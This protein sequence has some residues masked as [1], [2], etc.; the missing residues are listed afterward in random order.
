M[1]LIIATLIQQ[2]QQQYLLF[3]N[4][5]YIQGFGQYGGLVPNK[6]LLDE[7]QNYFY[8]ST[9]DGYLYSFKIETDSSTKEISL[10][11][12]DSLQVDSKNNNDLKFI[13][14]D[15]IMYTSDNGFYI[16]NI[17]DPSNIQIQDEN[18][19]SYKVYS[20]Y[21]FQ[22]QETLY[23]GS[24]YGLEIY[25]YQNIN[26]FVLIERIAIAGLGNK[27]VQIQTFTGSGI[28]LFDKSSYTIFFIQQ[29]WGIE[30]YE[31]YDGSSAGLNLISSNT[32]VYGRFDYGMLTSD[33][34]NPWKI[35]VSQ[36]QD[37]IFVTRGEDG[38][39]VFDTSDNENLQII[40]TYD[41]VDST[42][43]GQCDGL[44]ILLNSDGQETQYIAIA[45]SEDGVW[46]YDI[47]VITSPTLKVAYPIT[48]D[49]DQIQQLNNNPFILVTASGNSG[50]YVL[51]LS[52]SYDSFTTI[53]NYNDNLYYGTTESI[54]IKSDDS[55]ILT[56]VRGMGII[57]Y[58][59][60][61][62]YKISQ[63]TKV[64][65][66]GGEFAKWS[67][68]NENYFYVADGTQGLLIYYFDSINNTA[69]KISSLY[70]GGWA[71]KLSYNKEETHIFLSQIVQNQLLVINIKDLS[72][73]YLIE[74]LDGY[75]SAYDSQISQNVQTTDFE[76][77]NIDSTDS[78]LVFNDLRS[79]YIIDE[80]NFVN[81]EIFF[82]NNINFQ[83]S[84]IST[85]YEQEVLEILKQKIYYNPI[86]IIIE[87]S[88]KFDP[89]DENNSYIYTQAK[90]LSISIECLNTTKT[91]Q[92]IKK[93]YSSV[94][95]SYSSD[96]KLITLNGFTESINSALTDDLRYY[97]ENEEG[98]EILLKININD[99]INYE[100][101]E[102][103]KISD[104]KFLKST[105]YV[106]LNETISLQQQFNLK[107]KNGNVDVDEDVQFFMSS[108][109]FVDDDELTYLAYIKLSSETE[110]K[111]LG[112][113]S[114]YW[115]SF[116]QQSLQFKGSPD[117]YDYHTKLNL[118]I[119][120]TDG[121]TY[122]EDRFDINV[123]SLSL[124]I[125]LSYIGVI[126]GT[127]LF[128]TFLYLFRGRLFNI[129]C[130]RAYHLQDHYEIEAGQQFVKIVPI[131]RLLKN[132]G[133][134]IFSIFLK[135]IHKKKIHFDSLFTNF[136]QLKESEFVGI[137]NEINVKYNETLYKV[138]EMDQ[139]SDHLRRYLCYKMYQKKLK[140]HPKIEMLFT[141]IKEKAQKKQKLWYKV[142][143]DI[144]YQLIQFNRIPLPKVNFKVL[145]LRSMMSNLAPLQYDVDFQYEDF[146]VNYAEYVQNEYKEGFLMQKEFVLISKNIE[147]EALGFASDPI[148][149]YSN[150]ESLI[151]DQEELLEVQSL[152][153]RK[154]IPCKSICYPIYKYFNRDYQFIEMFSNSQ[155]PAWL[156]IEFKQD[157]V[158]FSG[159]PA[160]KDAG[161]IQIRMINHAS[162]IMKQF[163][164][165]IN[166][167]QLTL[168]SEDFTDGQ[169]TI[170]MIGDQ[171][172]KS[173][174]NQSAFSY[175]KSNLKPKMAQSKLIRQR[176]QSS[177]P[178]QAYFS[179]DNT[180]KLMYLTEQNNDTNQKQ[181]KIKINQGNL[182]NAKLFQYNSA[183]DVIQN[184][185][186]H[187]K[188]ANPVKDYQNTPNSSINNL[189]KT[190]SQSQS[191]SG[192][193]SSYSSNSQSETDKNESSYSGSLSSSGEES[194]SYSDD[195]TQKL[196]QQ[197]QQQQQ[198][199]E[200]SVLSPNIKNNDKEITIQQ[201]KNKKGVTFMQR[202]SEIN[203]ENQ[204]PNKINIPLNENE[205]K[206]E[207]N[208]ETTQ[209]N[210]NNN[211]Y[212]FGND[213]QKQN[214]K[215]QP[216]I[217]VSLA[218][219][220]GMIKNQNLNQDQNLILQIDYLN[221]NKNKNDIGSQGRTNEIQ[222]NDKVQE[223][224]EKPIYIALSKSGTI[225]ESY[226][227]PYF[228]AT[229]SKKN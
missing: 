216:K 1:L 77:I 63:V 53:D 113:Q 99:D 223:N 104:L 114:N 200:N 18:V 80:N 108:D 169:S 187:A 89:N 133:D 87:E 100:L 229:E 227:S 51:E 183:N 197:Q 105:D 32:D 71:M 42:N 27:Q 212:N 132:R 168:E 67:K 218:E 224:N 59:L 5:P 160:A 76:S 98:D 177:S 7:N 28:L 134:Q 163:T 178:L 118:K 66:Q 149:S 154:V 209:K 69:E 217:E 225:K 170:F 155:L 204:E 145:L 188:N 43:Q 93:T 213:V 95:S 58:T 60:D 61:D 121:Y 26:N 143:A 166:S 84:S 54:D 94:I 57:I 203:Q 33:G 125:I 208:N 96:Q 144:T 152:K 17:S 199:H 165:E 103:W 147:M 16:L 91:F 8:L 56:A 45:K 182:E 116:D 23:I 122:A 202:N 184:Q 206:K 29:Y 22:S 191:S 64:Y 195:E 172:S 62:D 70:S 153:K 226:N 72:S 128:L 151:C 228:N 4:F 129:C 109:T 90:E 194:Y 107:Y 39:V 24:S 201:D 112:Q 162:Q 171:K 141:V 161:E 13:Q 31:Y 220:K 41:I 30:V 88:L 115:L 150:S 221:N 52:S 47:S 82:K 140:K 12:L 192:Y 173:Q 196:Q 106:K 40:D 215:Q 2:S 65:T 25:D 156:K 73:P 119:I 86:Q 142:Y 48:G 83:D 20:F 127:L 205:L 110:W 117:I 3:T 49:T 146:D 222:L 46:V 102:T 148:F 167:D 81:R 11:Y 135:H 50:I 198:N 124:S 136:Y 92:F 214:L 190:A 37:I 79:Q 10:S 55:Y 6:F 38:I 74:T 78:Q 186:L 219:N 130:K 139:K 44:T 159:I 68:V 158:Q 97:M 138:R 15:Y 126:L 21:H 211:E 210:F 179:S 14:D 185:N 123:S 111:E 9:V 34:N 207:I 193:S 131:I 174:L 157:V 137:L 120:V 101:D 180:N 75:D 176:Q 175:K 35:V 19:S 36:D 181:N 85:T 189:N 164:I